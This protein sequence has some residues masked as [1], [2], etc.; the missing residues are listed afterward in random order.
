MATRRSRRFIPHGVNKIIDMLNLFLEYY[1]T[2]LSC[3]FCPSEP[4]PDTY[5]LAELAV[6]PYKS[7]DLGVRV[8]GGS[9]VMYAQSIVER[10]EPLQRLLTDYG[11]IDAFRRCFMLY[12][13][14]QPERASVL[15]DLSS[16]GC[17]Q[18]DT[19][20]QVAYKHHT[21]VRHLQRIRL[22][23]I[24]QIATEIHR[25]GKMSLSCEREYASA[26]LH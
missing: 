20:E 19:V 3:F 8:D 24:T 4:F 5:D 16:V 17:A 25:K 13:E 18:Y 26:S 12:Q 2:G 15:E 23:A 11:G 7:D 21:S 6:A 22:I 9:G 14:Q 1:V 10:A